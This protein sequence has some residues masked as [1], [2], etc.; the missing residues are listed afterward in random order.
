MKLFSQ[1]GLELTYMPK[2]Q[3]PDFVYQ[4][5]YA[6]EK[7]F[8]TIIEYAHHVDVLRGI[9]NAGWEIEEDDANLEVKSPKF[10][11]WEKFKLDY[12]KIGENL[13][14]LNFENSSNIDMVSEGGCHINFDLSAFELDEVKMQARLRNVINFIVDN[15]SI[16]WSFLSPFDNVSSRLTRIPN[17]KGEFLIAHYDTNK[18]TKPAV[19]ETVQI[20]YPDGRVEFENRETSESSSQYIKEYE[21][22]ELRF[23]MMPR[24]LK[25]LDLHFQFAN[26]LMNYTW[27]LGKSYEIDFDKVRHGYSKYNYGKAKSEILKVCEIIGFKNT[28]DLIEYKFPL[29]KQRMSKGPNYKK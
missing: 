12:S 22:L 19:Y 2:I 6:W 23:F 13:K 3:I 9:K 7:I 15:P 16:V 1:F 28:Q 10:S 4:S 11:S 27:G 21:R 17:S 8:S 20:T 26:A 29:L 25:E 18:I 5:Q 14:S 24:D